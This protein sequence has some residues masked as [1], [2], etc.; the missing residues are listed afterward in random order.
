MGHRPYQVERFLDERSNLRP[1]GGSV[2]DLQQLER[3]QVPGEG[4]FEKLGPFLAR[5]ALSPTPAV[6]EG[7]QTRIREAFVR[8]KKALAADYLDRQTERALLTLPL[9]A[10]PALPN[11]GSW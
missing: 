3:V 11:R 5:P 2:A 1:H 6:C 4:R 9:R 8:E 7:L 10:V